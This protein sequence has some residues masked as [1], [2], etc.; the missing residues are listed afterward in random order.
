MQKAE[1]G[2]QVRTQGRRAIALGGMVA[3]GQVGDAA[4]PG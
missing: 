3:T 2:C 1:L 4:F